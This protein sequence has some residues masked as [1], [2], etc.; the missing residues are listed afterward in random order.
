MF[1]RNAIPK[2]SLVIVSGIVAY[3][4]L[5]MTMARPA[6]LDGFGNQV[7]WEFVAV[8]VMLP[9][10]LLST[11]VIGLWRALMAKD[12]LWVALQLCFFPIAYVYTLFVNKGKGAGNSF[13]RNPSHRSV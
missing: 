2:I 13:K 6:P 5:V 9:L 12:Y 4:L 3:A 8:S 11:L 1:R 10:A 7:D